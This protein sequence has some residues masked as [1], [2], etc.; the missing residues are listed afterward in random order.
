[1]IVDAE[2]TA[3]GFS[4]QRQIEHSKFM[5]S[6]GSSLRLALCSIRYANLRSPL[7]VFDAIA[8]QFRQSSPALDILES[9]PILF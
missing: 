9:I 5:L 2:D 7:D 4:P 3:H 6:R 1:M 8:R